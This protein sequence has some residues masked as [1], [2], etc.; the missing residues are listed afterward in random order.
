[1][2]L[3]IGPE[4]GVKAIWAS[5]DRTA[6]KVYLYNDAGK[7]SAGECIPGESG[8]ISNAQGSIDCRQTT[9]TGSGS[10]MTVNWKITPKRSFAAPTAKKI[11]LLLRD[12]YN[13]NS[14]WALKGTWIVTP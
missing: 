4:T 1:M 10:N 7:A 11:W 5:Y 14:G 8:T 13:R 9:V 3:L 12:K 6:N 2:D